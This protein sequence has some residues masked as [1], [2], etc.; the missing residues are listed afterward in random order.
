MVNVDFVIKSEIVYKKAQCL[1]RVREQEGG[2]EK[3]EVEEE[4]VVLLVVE[5]LRCWGPC[6]MRDSCEVIVCVMF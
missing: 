1:R 4:E 5:E 3:E 6:R 2:R